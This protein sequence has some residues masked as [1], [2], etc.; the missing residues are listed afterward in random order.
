MKLAIMQ[1]YCLPYIGYFQLVNAVDK[2]IFYDDVN[3]IKQGWINRNRILNNGGALLF[4]IPVEKVSSFRKIN[5]TKINTTAFGTWS[6]KFLKTVGQ[7]YRKA[8]YYPVIHPLISNLLS[9]RYESISELAVRSVEEVMEYVG[10]RTEVV[11]TSVRY[12]NAHL[13]GQERVIDICRKEEASVYINPIGG[14]DLYEKEAFRGYGVELFYL[15]TN[16]ITYPQFGSQFVPWL[17]IID[18]LMFNS[19]ASIGEM[20]NAYSLI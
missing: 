10:I 5:E 13:K 15:R 14:V 12:G 16:P 7:T 18:V 6:Q 9:G 2:F 8:P 3:F 1:P 11:R 17:S 4:S 20:L 19:P